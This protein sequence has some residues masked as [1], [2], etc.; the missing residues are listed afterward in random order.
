MLF[1]FLEK[2]IAG[3]DSKPVAPSETVERLNTQPKPQE[4]ATAHSNWFGSKKKEPP[5]Q[6]GIVWSLC[7]SHLSVHMQDQDNLLF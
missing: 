1:F 7:Q 5:V 6:Q 4:E 2:Q 3:V